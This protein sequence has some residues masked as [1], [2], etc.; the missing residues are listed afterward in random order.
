[1]HDTKQTLYNSALTIIDQLADAEYDFERS[2]RLQAVI[3]ELAILRHMPDEPKAHARDWLDSL[4][5]W[6]KHSM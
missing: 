5:Y 3:V 4:D 6:D 2:A 1:M